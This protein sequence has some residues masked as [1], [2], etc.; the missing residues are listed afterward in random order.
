M[1][2]RKMSENLKEEIAKELG[3]YEIIKK[4]GWGAVTSRDCGNLLTRTG[5]SDRSPEK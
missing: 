2:K 4:A 1:P 3:L 5:F